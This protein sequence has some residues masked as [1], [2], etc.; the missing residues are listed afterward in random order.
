MLKADG[1]IPR[2]QNREEWKGKQELDAI[3]DEKDAEEE[4]RIQ[5]IEDG[6]KK[7]SRFRV[8]AERLSISGGSRRIA[9]AAVFRE[10]LHRHEEG[11]AEPIS[12]QNAAWREFRRDDH[13]PAQHEA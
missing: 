4:C 2:E 11:T 10:A 13:R 3:L 7:E 9:D 5:A 6:R 12:E 8:V 1:E